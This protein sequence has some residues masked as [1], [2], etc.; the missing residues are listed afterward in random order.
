M[1][2]RQY[3]SDCYRNCRELVQHVCILTLFE[4]SPSAQEWRRK[5]AYQTILLLRVT[6]A[7]I[8]VGCLHPLFESLWCCCCCVCLL[9]GMSDGLLTVFYSDLS[10]W[11]GIVSQFIDQYVGRDGRKFRIAH[12]HDTGSSTIGLRHAL[13]LDSPKSTNFQVGSRRTY[14]YVESIVVQCPVLCRN[15]C[16]NTYMCVCV[17]ILTHSNILSLWW[18]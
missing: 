18:L 11:L 14:Q 13:G 10:F 6:M 8:E 4:D 15:T 1:E 9:D 12:A 17:W 16:V 2:S 5:V 3:L 7:A